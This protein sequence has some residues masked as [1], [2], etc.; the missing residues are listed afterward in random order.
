MALKMIHNQSTVLKI[1]SS[2][3]IQK[4]FYNRL[5]RLPRLYK[6]IKIARIVKMVKK[7][8]HNKYAEYIEEY[9]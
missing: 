3:K 5:T 4:Y 9:F 7:A 8:R 1:I 6:L 2:I